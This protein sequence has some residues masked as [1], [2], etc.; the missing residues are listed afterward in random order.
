MMALA[1][2]TG[3]AAA[4]TFMTLAPSTA[5]SE[6]QAPVDANGVEGKKKKRRMHKSI[7]TVNSL[8]CFFF[9]EK[10]LIRT[11]CFPFTLPTTRSGNGWL[12]WVLAK[13]AS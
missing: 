7:S 12:A 6:A 9:L 3:M 5:Y 10:T 2:V 8:H 13:S 4:G 11:W 1:S